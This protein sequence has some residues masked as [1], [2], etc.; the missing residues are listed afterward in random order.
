MQHLLNYAKK[1]QIMQ[2]NT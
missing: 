2:I 1:H